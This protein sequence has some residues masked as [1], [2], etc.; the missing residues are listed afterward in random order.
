M[1]ISCLKSEVSSVETE[2]LV[3]NLFEDVKVPA[4]ATGA[5]DTVTGGKISR[6]IN[7]GEI[8]GKK[9]E[10]TIIHTFG[11]FKFERII[12]CGLGKQ[13]KF[14]YDSIRQVMAITMRQLRKI[15]ISQV[16]TICHGAGIAGLDPKLCA[17]AITEGALLGTYQFTKYK[18]SSTSER[19]ESLKIIENDDQKIQHITDGITDGLILSDSTIIARDL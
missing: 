8:S 19:I 15:K 13:E 7:S 17:V 1:E 16:A 12:I 9:N 2:A 18:N 11:E 5:I 4:G 3:I 6:L 10:I 14:D